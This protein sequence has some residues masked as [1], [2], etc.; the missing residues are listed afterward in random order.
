[1]IKYE[2]FPQKIQ[3]NSTQFVKESVGLEHLSLDEKQIARQMSVVCGDLSILENTRFSE[4]A[5]EKALE[6]LDEDY[7]LLCDTA[8]VAC[9]LKN[10]YLKEE[11]I[12]LINKAN[13]ISQAKAKK[14]TR[15]MTAVDLWKPYLPESIIIIGYE[16]TALFRLLEILEGIS[17]NSKKPALIIA[18]PVGFG[19][20]EVAK[21]YLWDNCEKLEI[22]C[23]TLLGTRGGNDIAA[24]IMN[25][26]LQMHKLREDK[27]EA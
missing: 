10:K 15:S 19:G 6:A 26:L 25:K 2:K 16:S 14:H 21:Q 18:T 5:I 9:A 7:D 3:I 20:A 1:M 11:P 22:P 4:G 12:C 23:I 8:T 24:S 27:A 17:E 13:V